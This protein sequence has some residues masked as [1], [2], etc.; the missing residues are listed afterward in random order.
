MNIVSKRATHEGDQC[1][2]IEGHGPGVFPGEGLV[3][4]AG[5]FARTAAEGVVAREDGAVG[6]FGSKEAGGIEGRDVVGPN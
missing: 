2:H 5:P 3:G 1:L 4:D 6:E